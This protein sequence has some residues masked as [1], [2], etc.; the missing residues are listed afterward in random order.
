MALD[1]RS[2][3]GTSWIRTVE[4]RRL[5]SSAMVMVADK[6]RPP[7]AQSMPLHYGV[8]ADT[9]DLRVPYALL[10]KRTPKPS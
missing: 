7:L 4:H 8:T 3:T 2:G 9:T 6:L 1:S 5:I 10:C